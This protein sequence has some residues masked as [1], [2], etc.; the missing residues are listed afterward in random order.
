MDM[1]AGKK[2]SP[3]ET[4]A[5]GDTPDDTARAGPTHSQERHKHHKQQPTASDAREL[6][7]RSSKSP[8][9]GFKANAPPPQPATRAF[10]M[11]SLD[12]VKCGTIT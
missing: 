4:A 7:S 11:A 6:T 2:G 1:E 3:G 9:H 10:F 8:D 5:P 12:I